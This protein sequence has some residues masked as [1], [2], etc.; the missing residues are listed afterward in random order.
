[1]RKKNVLI[2]TMAFLLFS[3]KEDKKEVLL[4]DI[5]IGNILVMKVP[6]EM[7]FMEGK[8]ID[9]YVAYLINDKED[10]FHIEYG[11]KG[12]INSLYNV[13]PPVFLLSQ[14]ETILKTSV[15]EPLSDEVLF[16]E[17]PEEDTEQKIFDKNYF[18]YDTVNTI[19]AKLVQP[20]KIG[21]GITGLYVPKLKDGKSFSIYAHNLDSV[22]HRNA[23]Q[24]F[25]TIKYK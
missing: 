13:S 1:M 19:V 20:K 7:K 10:T 25:E 4:R 14:K 23:L 18:L 3:C 12:I 24:M 8:G 16:S 21:D 9:S 6:N 17:Y 15:K 22:D 2:L 11:N 5:A